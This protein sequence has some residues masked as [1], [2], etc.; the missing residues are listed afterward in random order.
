MAAIPLPFCTVYMCIYTWKSQSALPVT[1]MASVG[2]LF[3]PTGNYITIAI[4]LRLLPISLYFFGSIMHLSVLRKS[5]SHRRWQ[6]FTLSPKCMFLNTCTTGKKKNKSN[7]PKIT[8]IHCFR[9]MSKGK[10]YKFKGLL[11]LLNTL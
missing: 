6:W 8:E 3:L 9:F 2:H 5:A 10:N 1:I 4:T 7:T 11:S